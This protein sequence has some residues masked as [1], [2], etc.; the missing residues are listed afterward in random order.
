MEKKQTYILRVWSGAPSYTEAARQHN[1]PMNYM[2]FRMTCKSH[3]TV[4]KKLKSAVMDEKRRG[5]YTEYFHADD[6]R[7]EIISTPNGYDEERVV[8]TGLIEEI[9]KS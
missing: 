7:Y 6:A 4:L 9:I 2:F 5:L 8:S 1:D 3:V